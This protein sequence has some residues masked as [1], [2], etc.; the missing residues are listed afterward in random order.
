M[1]G[2]GKIEGTIPSIYCSTVRERDEFKNLSDELRELKEQLYTL[3]KLIRRVESRRQH[4]RNRWYYRR[5]KDGG[6][7]KIL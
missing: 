5:G 3:Q 2:R 6:S 1:A 7:E 4:I